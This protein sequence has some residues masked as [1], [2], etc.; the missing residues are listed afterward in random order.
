MTEA[1]NVGLTTGDLRR[2][3]E[4]RRG[5]GRRVLALV[6]RERLLAAQVIPLCP[7]RAG[8]LWLCLSG[9]CPPPYPSRVEPSSVLGACRV[10]GSSP[11]GTLS[12]LEASRGFSLPLGGG[13]SGGVALCTSPG[14]ACGGMPDGISSGS[15]TSSVGECS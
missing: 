13:G 3:L 11:G 14:G 8:N 10:L 15:G 2:A 6:V 5:P 7:R 1:R 12:A 9:P 4:M